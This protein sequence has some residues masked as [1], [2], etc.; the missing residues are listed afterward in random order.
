[1]TRTI[2][3]VITL[4]VSSAYAQPLAKAER[5]SSIGYPSV[6]AA[7]EAL[8]ARKDVSISVQTGWTVIT[9]KDGLTLWSFTPQSHPAYPAAIKR[10]VSEENGAWIMHMD[11]LC[12]ADKKP[13][14]KLVEDFQ[15]LNEQ[16]RQSI[17][18]EHKAQQG[19][20]GDG[21]RPTGSAHP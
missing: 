16:M 19:A 17:E 14:D 7:M 20:P 10:T 8:R 9:E 21:P 11:V 5:I 18:R 15:A 1:M 3:V 2:F 6:A 13:C 12:E 4:I